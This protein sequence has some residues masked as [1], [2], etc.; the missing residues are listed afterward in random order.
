MRKEMFVDKVHLSVDGQAALAEAQ[1]NT[2]KNILQK[3]SENDMKVDGNPSKSGDYRNSDSDGSDA[4]SPD[5]WTEQDY[6][7]FLNFDIDLDGSDDWL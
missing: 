3:K 4:S 6:D 7:D 2:V 1:A 5:W